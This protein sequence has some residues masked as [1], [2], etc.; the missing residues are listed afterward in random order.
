MNENRLQIL[1]RQKK[2]WKERKIKTAETVT[3]NIFSYTGQYSQPN[4][5]KK[6][7]NKKEIINIFLLFTKVNRG[8][9]YV[10]DTSYYLT[11]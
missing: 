5:Q 6:T 8:R 9:C 2:K 4:K 11:Q 3:F 1:I 10:Y 7:E